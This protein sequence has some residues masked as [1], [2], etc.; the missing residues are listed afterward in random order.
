MKPSWQGQALHTLKLTQSLTGKK[1][2]L[3]LLRWEGGTEC[4]L[5]L[6]NQFQ[7]AADLSEWGRTP[8]FLK[9][10]HTSVF[11]NHGTDTSLV[12][13]VKRKHARSPCCIYCLLQIKREEGIFVFQS[14]NHTLFWFK[15]SKQP[16]VLGDLPYMSFW[17]KRHFQRFLSAVTFEGKVT[18]PWCQEMP[19][20]AVRVILGLD[21]SLSQAWKHV[22]FGVES[23]IKDHWCGR[24]EV[25]ILYRG[26]LIYVV[27]LT[28][29]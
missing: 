5:P 29:T 3:F 2:F 7:C 27:Q 15:P 24:C 18:K 14:R 12:E 26:F 17:S 10:T 1:I 19:E 8:A 6:G 22:L 11:I 4:F 9:E 16:H 21:A 13:S 28:L 25:F 23:N 20:I